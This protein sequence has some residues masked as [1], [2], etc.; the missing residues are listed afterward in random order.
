M[1]FLLCFMEE[2][3]TVV[4]KDAPPGP[5]ECVTEEVAMTRE[6][7]GETCGFRRQLDLCQSRKWVRG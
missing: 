1:V 6:A 7:C 3:Q 5:A 2:T 4:W